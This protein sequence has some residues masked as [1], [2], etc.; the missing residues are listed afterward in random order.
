VLSFLEVLWPDFSI[1]HLYAAVLHYQKCYPTVHVSIS[2][3]TM[4]YISACHIFRS[5]ERMC[6][7]NSKSKRW[8]KVFDIKFKTYN[9]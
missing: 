6:A 1:W 2:V 4:C 9:C 8:F 5:K 3:C 7:C